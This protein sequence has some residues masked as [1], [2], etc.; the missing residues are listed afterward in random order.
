MLTLYH[1]DLPQ[2]LQ[3]IGGWENEELV[4]HFANY[5]R[6]CYDNFGDRVSSH[7]TGNH[8]FANQKYALCLLLRKKFYDINFASICIFME[9]FM[10]QVEFHINLRLM[11]IISYE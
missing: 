1:W 2:A 7:N 8:F 9:L 5:A 3:D 11:L 6:V 4:D 10:A